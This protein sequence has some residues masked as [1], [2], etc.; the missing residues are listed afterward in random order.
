MIYVDDREESVKRLADPLRRRGLAVKVVRLDAADVAFFGRGPGDGRGEASYGVGIEIKK[1]PDLINCIVN[2]RFADVQLPRLKTQYQA[3]WLMALG[4]W[5]PGWGEHAGRLMLPR[6]RAVVPFHYEGMKRAW[7]WRDVEHWLTTMR[8]K[9]GIQVDRAKNK[10]ELLAKLHA[11][12]TWWTAVGWDGHT[13]HE[14]SGNGFDDEG[15]RAWAVKP[16]MVV[17]MARLV[18]GVG[19]KKARRIAEKLATAERLVKASAEEIGKALGGTP[20]AMKLGG[21]VWKALRKT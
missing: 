3:V 15:A 2:K 21:E 14:A 18:E 12:Y 16:P 17:G 13:A 7:M 1:L 8:M 19:G 6:K 4:E 20:G 5:L 10:A 11:L 9:A